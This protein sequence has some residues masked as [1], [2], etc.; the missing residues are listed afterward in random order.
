M[1]KKP[2]IWIEKYRC[3]NLTTYIGNDTLKSYIDECIKKHDIPHLLF[4]GTQGTGKTTLAKIIINNIDCDYLYL[5]ASDERGIDVIRDKI[6]QFAQASTFKK[7]KVIVLDEADYITST[8]QAALRNVIETYSLKTRF[9]LTANYLERIIEPLQSRFQVFK[10]EPPSKGE[11]AKHIAENI[12]PL[13]DIKFEIGDLVEIINKFYPD[14][15]K[16]I[17]VCQQS[18]KEGVL[19]PDFTLLG[20]NIEEVID[21]II[22]ELKKPSKNSW[23]NIRQKLADGEIYDYAQLYSKLYEKV[24][25]YG[26]GNEGDIAIH[27]A[28][29][30]WSHN[31]VSDKELNFMACVS[32]ILNSLK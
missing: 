7:L 10:I 12:L 3:Q 23:A 22:S 11:V 31:T 14:I 1:S 25:E 32:Q 17:G 30:L 21:D 8:A 5:N 2:T 26:K 20:G 18:I 13:E 15:R 28:Q 16:I 4:T 9:I 24:S 19:A 6:T 27:L 29:Y